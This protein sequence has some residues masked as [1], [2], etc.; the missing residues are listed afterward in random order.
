MCVYGNYASRHAL[1][2]TRLRRPGARARAES[3]VVVFLPAVRGAGR[4]PP[5][6]L[7][8]GRGEGAPLWRESRRHVSRWPRLLAAA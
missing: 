8:R 2:A 1:R 7:P 4:D 3:G 6:S 5:S